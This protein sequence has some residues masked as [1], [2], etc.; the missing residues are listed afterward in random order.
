MRFSTKIFFLAAT[1]FSCTGQAKSFAE[2]LRFPTEAQARQLLIQEDSFTKAWSP[3]D[4]QSRLGDSSGTRADLMAFIPTQ[5]LDWRPKERKRI[6]DLARA[7]DEKIAELGWHIQ[8]PDTVYILK[9]TGLE[10]GGAAGYTRANYIVLQENLVRGAQKDLQNLLSH[11]LFHILSRANP[12]LRKELYAI[13]GFDLMPPLP[14]P[15]EIDRLRISNPDAVQTNHFIRIKVKSKEYK[16]MMVLYARKAY[17][18]GSFFN[19]LTIG[20]LALGDEQQVLRGDS[21]E[22]VIFKTHEVEGFFEQVGR[23]TEYLIHPEEILAENFR[24]ALW[25]EKVKDHFIL[26]KIDKLLKAS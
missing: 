6:I 26:H 8:L 13:I 10:E 21:G 11:E 24:L 15:E 2:S 19:Y 12:Q 4:I 5:V 25:Q 9:T 23:N 22:V 17:E 14:Y 1:L 16:A 18:G 7:I 20:F 3:F